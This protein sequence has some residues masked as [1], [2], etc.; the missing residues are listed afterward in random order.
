MISKTTPATSMSCVQ[1]G[2]W[3]VQR[4]VG[5][6]SYSSGSPGQGLV[7]TTSSKGRRWGGKTTAITRH[8]KLICASCRLPDTVVI[9]EVVIHSHYGILCAPN[10]TQVFSPC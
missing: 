5:G 7:S 10:T 9:Q 3:S 4:K 1:C 2:L 6:G 8:R